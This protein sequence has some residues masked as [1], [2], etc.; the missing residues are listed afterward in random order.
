MSWAEIWFL[1]IFLSRPSIIL[2]QFFCAV[3]YTFNSHIQLKKVKKLHKSSACND[4]NLIL[5]RTKFYQREHNYCHLLR[6]ILR[7]LQYPGNEIFCFINK[8]V[9]TFLWHR[10]FPTNKALQTVMGFCCYDTRIYV[11][12]F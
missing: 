7:F 6:R 1:Q 2:P 5:T 4:E 11:K 3:P 12:H 9:K 8:N 10:H